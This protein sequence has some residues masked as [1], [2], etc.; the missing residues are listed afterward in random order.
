MPVFFLFIT[1]LLFLLHL[2]VYYFFVKV[3]WLTWNIKL[4]LGVIFLLLALSYFVAKLLTFKWDNLFTKL[5]HYFSSFWLWFFLILLIVVITSC[6]LLII[7]SVLDLSINLR[8][9]WFWVLLFTLILSLVWVWVAYHP[10]IE[11]KEVTIK[12]LPSVWEDKKV[13][14]FSDLH[15]WWIIQQRYFEKIVSQINDEKPDLVLIA[16]DL[17][18]WPGSDYSYFKDTI[19]KIE[20]PDW[21]YF[22]VWNHDLHLWKDR[23][24][25]LFEW[26][27]INFLD[28]DFILLDWVQIVWVDSQIMMHKSTTNDLENILNKLANS[29]FDKTLPTILLFHEPH[30][31]DTFKEFW[32]DL[33]LSWHTHEWQMWPIWYIAKRMNFWNLYWLEEVEDYT[34]YTSSW[35]WTWWPPMR[36]WTISEMVVIELKNKNTP[37]D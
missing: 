37:K 8:Y 35:L 14:F 26:T 13:I 36:L 25:E 1:L 33:Q 32:V 18:D 17:F 22:V 10:K 23:L 3:F 5:F 11:L 6:I 28:N 9:I 34:I 2:F 21:I 27:K 12:W 30:H 4:A 19:N 16:W 29:W 24:K 15:L 7:A 31:L 20:A